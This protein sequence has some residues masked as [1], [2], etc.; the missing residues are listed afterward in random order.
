[1]RNISVIQQENGWQPRRGGSHD[2]PNDISVV[3]DFTSTLSIYGVPGGA[4][5]A[6]A[7]E[8]NSPGSERPPRGRLRSN[9]ETGS[10]RKRHSKLRCRLG[11]ART[12]RR[13]S[14]NPLN[15][16]SCVSNRVC[17][18]GDICRRVS[19]HRRQLPRC[20]DR[21]A[22]CNDGGFPR[23]FHKVNDITFRLSFASM[24]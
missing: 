13:F 2:Y 15:D 12:R 6:L 1:M 22:D 8:L 11:P 23:F 21:C 19:R 17:N 10:L 4:R 20:Q 18:R 14:L 3:P 9:G 16:P 7:D 24:L 5:R